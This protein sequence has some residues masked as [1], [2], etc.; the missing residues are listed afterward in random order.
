MKISCLLFVLGALLLSSC[1]VVKS[2]TAKTMDVYGAGVIQNP[3]VVDL[4]V[5]ETK[6]SGSYNASSTMG[7]ESIKQ[8]AVADAL[9]KAGADVLVEPV[10]E[11]TTS[12][13]RTTAK[14]TGYPA[15]YSNFRSIEKEDIELL[16][17]GVTQK[18]TVYKP[19]E[20]KQKSK[21]G[22]VIGGILLTGA[23]LIGLMA[24]TGGL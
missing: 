18:A 5:S 17:V 24:L 14:V 3:V 7:V 12:T 21:A 13:G 16:E 9:S 15:S 6:I 8:Y 19:V 23:V 20:T 4:Q 11:T 10:F 2:K 1:A 22:S